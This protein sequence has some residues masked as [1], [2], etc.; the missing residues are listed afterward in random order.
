MLDCREPVT[1]T[2]GRGLAV[3]R[4]DI[5]G[6]VSCVRGVGLQVALRMQMPG[7]KPESDA[8]ETDRFSTLEGALACL[9]HDFRVSGIRAQPDEPQLPL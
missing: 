3:F 8:E 2:T 5:T 9:I 1:G 4:W 6:G 7:K